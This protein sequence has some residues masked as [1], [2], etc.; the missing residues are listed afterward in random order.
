MLFL[1]HCTSFYGNKGIIPGMFTLQVVSRAFILEQLKA[2]NP[3][4]GTVLDGIGPRFLKDGADALADVVT[5][6]VNLSI[7]SK[8]VPACTKHAKVI[9]MYK[10]NSMLDVVNYRPSVF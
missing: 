5:Y 3:Q 2:L 10:K 1:D 6:L 9:P 8:I 4:K 7:T